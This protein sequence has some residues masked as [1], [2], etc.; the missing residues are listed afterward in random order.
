M[1]LFSSLD[2]IRTKLRYLDLKLPASRDVTI[3]V[4]EFP[5]RWMKPEQIE[6]LLGEMRQIVRNGIGH[7]LEYGIL[8]GDPERLRQGIVT[9]LY[10]KASGNAIAFNALS[11]M[12]M[13][14]RSTD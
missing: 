2:S 8:T 14:L 11:A 4:I 10:D 5:G 9:L 7:D 1:R 12:P 6:H 3:R 13:E